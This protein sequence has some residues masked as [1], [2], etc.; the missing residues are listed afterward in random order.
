MTINASQNNNLTSGLVGLWSFDGPDVSG[1]TAYD[2]S[3]NGNNGTISGATPT[4]GKIGQGMSF[5]GVDDIITTASFPISDWQTVQG[6]SV[7]FWVKDWQ[8]LSD[9]G[10]VEIW[11]SFDTD[12]RIR[13]STDAFAPYN[14]IMAIAGR[15]FSNR[16]IEI[17]SNVNL[18]SDWHMIAFT[19][20]NSGGN[21]YIDGV[22]D[23]SD[24]VVTASGSMNLNS[25]RIG[26][27]RTNRDATSGYNYLQSSIDEVRMYNRALSGDEVTALYNMGKV[28]IKN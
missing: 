1:S 20:N 23:N 24:S 26:S 8:N 5:D 9:K 21:L 17:H 6:A 18:N 2:R 12:R 7:A 22:L 13:I 3:G 27:S 10:A 28:R 15:Q 16:E 14:R 19:I 4:L 11:D 25:M